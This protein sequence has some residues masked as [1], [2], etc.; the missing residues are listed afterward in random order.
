M[1]SGILESYLAKSRLDTVAENADMTQ[2]LDALAENSQPGGVLYGRDTSC[3][4]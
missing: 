3:A 4:R 1:V 2:K